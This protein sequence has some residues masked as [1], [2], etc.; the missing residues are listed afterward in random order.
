MII[1]AGDQQGGKMRVTVATVLAACLVTGLAWAQ[2]KTLASEET[3]ICQGGD[4]FARISG[5]DVKLHKDPATGQVSLVSKFTT[6]GGANAQTSGGQ[7]P[8]VS[9]DVLDQSGSA[10]ASASDLVAVTWGCNTA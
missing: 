8:W 2:D 4:F 3:K 5:A 6:Q 1:S 9:V 7:G 10:I